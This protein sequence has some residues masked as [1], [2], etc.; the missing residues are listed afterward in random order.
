MCGTT[1]GEMLGENDNGLFSICNFSAIRIFFGSRPQNVM[2]DRLR[3]Q[4]GTC[5]APWFLLRPLVTAFYQMTTC[6]AAVLENTFLFVF[7]PHTFGESYQC[8]G[9]FKKMYL[10][11][12]DERPAARDPRDSNVHCTSYNR[13][14]RKIG[15]IGILAPFP[16]DLLTVISPLDLRM[17]LK[18]WCDLFACIACD[19]GL[20]Q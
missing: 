19:F 16:P 3:T 6:T 9:F 12:T 2:S 8:P 20:S 1:C 13:P 10:L 14:V 5:Q 18:M 17:M 7:Y 11:N 15:F 4:I